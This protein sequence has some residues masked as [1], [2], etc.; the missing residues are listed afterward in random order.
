MRFLL[1]L[2]LLLL[3]GLPA[4]AQTTTPP[5]IEAPACFPLINGV[6]V[7][8]P[9]LVDGEL[10]KHIYWACS[11]RGG[12]AK[13]Y[14]WSCP[15]GQ[16]LA[17][18][19]KGALQLITSAT[20]KVSTAQAQYQAAMAFDCPQVVKEESPRGALCRERER[21]MLANILEWMKDGE[22]GQ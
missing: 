15:H 20:A 19:A 13:V 9:R 4:Q 16:C 21:L 18:A 22:G 6:H 10:G 1:L 7:F 11:P 14:G 8:S 17:G 12:N 3:G 2:P 5:A